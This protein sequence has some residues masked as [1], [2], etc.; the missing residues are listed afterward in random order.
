MY[1]NVLSNSKLRTQV[2]A[3]TGQAKEESIV[4]IAEYMV[5]YITKQQQQQQAG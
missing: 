3:F 2:D 5:V 4:T 1:L